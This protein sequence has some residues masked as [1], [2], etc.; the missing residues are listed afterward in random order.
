MRTR[1]AQRFDASTG[2][3]EANPPKRVV[4]DLHQMATCRSQAVAASFTARVEIALAS[5]V[6]SNIAAWLLGEL[7]SSDEFVEFLTAPAYE[8]VNAVVGKEQEAA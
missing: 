4:F 3:S 7:V 1:D 5:T 8:I 6:R 2:K